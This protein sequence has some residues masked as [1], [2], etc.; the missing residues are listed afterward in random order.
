M[1]IPKE[2]DYLLSLQKRKDSKERIK[3]VYDA[4]VYKKSKSKGYF[5]CP[6][7]YLLKVS[8]RYNKVINLLLE[9]KII[10]YQSFNYDESNIFET[11]RKPYYDTEKGI[12]KKYKFLIDIENGYEDELLIDFSNLYNNNKWYMKTRYSLL[13]LGYQPEELNIKRDNFSRR[14][15]TNITG[16]IGDG[17]SYKD[18]LSGGDYYTID[19]KTCQ[20]RLL[21]LH[22]QE[23]GLQDDKLNEIFEN[24]LDFYDFIIQRIPA[25]ID[26]DDAKELFTSWINGTGYLDIDKTSIRDIFPVVNM[27]LRRYKTTNYK[28][29]CRLLQYR[30]ASIFIDD[31]LNN[32]PIDFCLTIHDSLVIKKEDKDVALEYCK[33]KY[34]ELIFILE[35]I[36]RR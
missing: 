22:L 6:S 25:L 30:E 13:Q 7:A 34:P 19:A 15:H 1:I 12:C 23:I 8:P 29:V 33:N 24:G 5:S 18:L 32:I 14:L 3:K 20:P 10:E 16:N 27:F 26:R 2:L 9:H 28:N 11:R 17:N 31:L 36:K 21:W 35:E 4:L